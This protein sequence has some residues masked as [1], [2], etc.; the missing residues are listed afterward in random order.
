MGYNDEDGP[1][2][3]VKYLASQG[4]A[5]QGL[6][7]TKRTTTGE[8]V[9]MDAADVIAFALARDESPPPQV[10]EGSQQ[11][12]KFSFP[13]SFRLDEFITISRRRSLEE[14]IAEEGRPG[15]ESPGPSS[16]EQFQQ[17]KVTS[18]HNDAQYYVDHR[19]LIAPSLQYDLRAVLMHDGLTGR[20]HVY[21]YI[22]HNDTWW[23][24]VNYAV[25]QVRPTFLR[26]LT[27][28]GTANQSH[29]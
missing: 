3:L 27:P 21:S 22:N 28:I 26:T 14:N 8:H 4:F 10:A 20:E 23:K 6:P 1:D 11:R 25:T 13:E 16:V 24:I 12:R 29:F 17:D 19:L 5:T 9:V 2:D 15:T 7:N 18:R